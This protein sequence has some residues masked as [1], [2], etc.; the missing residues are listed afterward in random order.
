MTMITHWSLIRVHRAFV[1]LC[2]LE[3]MPETHSELS[4]TLNPLSANS[5]EWLN[6]LKELFECVW[7]FYETGAKRIKETLE[8]V[9]VWNLKVKRSTGFLVEDSR[10]L[11]MDFSKIAPK[12]LLFFVITNRRHYKSLTSKNETV[13]LVTCLQ[14]ITMSVKTDFCRKFLCS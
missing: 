14:S 12:L 8:F 6:T 7:S 3:Y 11:L 2:N 9:F 10:M 4:E 13:S 1:Q 5:T